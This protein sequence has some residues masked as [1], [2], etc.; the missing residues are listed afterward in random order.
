VLIAVG[1]QDTL[2]EAGEL[3][4]G[5]IQRARRGHYA[6]TLLESLAV[7]AL[8]HEA[9]GERAAATQALRE[10][11]QMAAPEGIVQRYAYLGPAVVPI[12][13]RL[14]T[15]LDTAPLARK[16]LAALESVLAFH[17]DLPIPEPP[18]LPTMLSN[19]L[20]AREIEVLHCLARRLTND[21]I[22]DELFISP[23]TVKH[24]VANLS[25]KLAV[26]GRR[27]A[28]ARATELGLIG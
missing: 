15:E 27:A 13:R 26:S 19:P 24:H 5:F 6:L 25:G 18:R 22:G 20:S 10:S 17:P 3:L 28:V 7:L 2:A 4:T 8:L 23:I 9:R 11:L 16:V 14:L 12:L 1:T 21:E